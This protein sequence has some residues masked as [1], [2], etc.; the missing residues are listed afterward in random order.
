[1][2][3]AERPR[4][5]LTGAEFQHGR[6][7]HHDRWLCSTELPMAPLPLRCRLNATRLF[8][9]SRLVWCGSP[10]NV[11]LSRGVLPVAVLFQAGAEWS[12]SLGTG[13]RRKMRSTCDVLRCAVPGRE[14]QPVDSASW[15]GEPWPRSR[16][17]DGVIETERN[18]CT[19]P[20]RC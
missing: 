18:H 15:N 5:W 2:F 20:F 14:N 8:R 4:Q 3:T 10:D 1:M 13:P 17:D 19:W 9:R 6:A 7:R 12:D 16:A 11:P